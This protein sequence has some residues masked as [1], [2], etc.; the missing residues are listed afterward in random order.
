M[1]RQ[2]SGSQLDFQLLISLLAG[3]LAIV[4]ANV[5]WTDA[6]SSHWEVPA[7]AALG[8]GFLAYSPLL[9]EWRF[10]PGSAAWNEA[11]AASC[12]L[13][14]GSVLWLLRADRAPAAAGTVFY[15]LV[16]AALLLYVGARSRRDRLTVGPDRS[17]EP[18]L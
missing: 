9:S 10:P 17:I 8:A 15:F 6:F 4:V 16:S 11:I 18:L 14:F 7:I 12:V 1:D 3:G 5:M 13:G 2:V